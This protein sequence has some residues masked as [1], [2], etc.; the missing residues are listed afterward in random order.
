MW[1]F[2]LELTT[3]RVRESALDDRTV[4][5]PRIDERLTGS[6]AR[7]T[8]AVSTLNRDANAIVR[9]DLLGGSEPVEHDLGPGR[10]PG[11]PVFVPRAVDAA[12][13]DGWLVAF[14]YDAA[15]DTSDVVVYAADD[16]PAGP[17][18]TVHLPR[19]IPYGFHG[20]WIGESHLVH[21]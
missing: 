16:L 3:G 18:A 21:R 4:E 5:F 1:R 14:A 8:Y 15:R 19:R 17:V 12:E 6:P 20:T 7:W 13:D 10:V 11:E 2:T 9:Y